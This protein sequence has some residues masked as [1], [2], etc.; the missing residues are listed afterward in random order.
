MWKRRFLTASRLLMSGSIK[1]LSIKTVKFLKRFFKA[2]SEITYPKWRE[3]WVELDA[4][5]RKQ[6]DKKISSLPSNSTFTIFL[7]VNTNNSLEAQV[8]IKSLIGQRY[9]KWNLQLLGDKSVVASLVKEID[10]SR[11]ACC[12]YS[13]FDQEKG[14]FS[15]LNSGDLLHEAALFVIAKSII[16]NPEAKIFYTDQDH[17][18]TE[19]NF[20]D[21]FFKPNWNEDLFNGVN[22]FGIITVFSNELWKENSHDPFETKGLGINEIAKIDKTHIIHLPYVLASSPVQNDSSCLKLKAQRIEYPLPS[23]PPKVSVLIPTKNKGRMLERCLQS[24]RNKTDYLD[25]E[26]VIVDHESTEKYARKI[27]D[28][29]AEETDTKV[30]EYSGFFNFSAM[31]NRAATVASGEV[32]ILL[33]N[34]TEVVNSDW[35][36]EMVVQVSRSGVGIVGA[37]LVFNNGT[38]QHAGVNP[39]SEGLMIHSHKH[40][41]ENSPGYFGRLLVAHEV[42]AVTGACL[43]IKNEDWRKL[44]GLDEENLA[45]A[46][47]DIDLCFKARAQGLKVLLTPHAKL[48]HQESVTRGFDDTSEKVSRLN[49]ELSVMKT[50][51]QELLDED[52]A[53][54]VNLSYNKISFRNLSD[55]PRTKPIWDC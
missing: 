53:Y 34:D 3:K 25:L 23:P 21:P 50:R 4:S 45:V 33:N 11:V 37:L 39:N 22:Y 46:Y 5:Q 1:D 24:L 49:E 14:W 47:N 51:W 55:P 38:I 32:L 13:S 10:D 20:Q 2:D 17:L 36:K 48:L 35:L 18:S 15:F 52:P 7:F 40:W 9:L 19:G 28:K 16:E 43:A 44:G 27:I 31:I 6:I 54:S 42:A 29:A 30:I 8:T 12:N 41:K 26:I